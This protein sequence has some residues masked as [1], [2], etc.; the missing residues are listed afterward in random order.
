[1]CSF[2]KSVVTGAYD[3]IGYIYYDATDYTSNNL[4][5]KFAAD[6]YRKEI[7]TAGQMLRLVAFSASVILLVSAC[8]VHGQI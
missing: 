8:I 4:Y 1:M 6:L 2:I 5:N 7:V 3:G